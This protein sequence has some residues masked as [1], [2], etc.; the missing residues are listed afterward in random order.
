MNKE[1]A[2]I[3]LAQLESDIEELRKIINKPEQGGIGVVAK[4]NYGDPFA[5]IIP[6][7]SANTPEIASH[8]VKAIQTL[9]RLLSMA[10]PMEENRT[11]WQIVNHQNLSI[12]VDNYCYNFYKLS[13]ISPCF[14]TEE[15]A[16]KAIDT[17]GE[18]AILH[19]MNTFKG[20]YS[21]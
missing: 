11:Q 2:E 15:A 12:V 3:K 4:Y 1:Q 18:E 20:I 7:L 8:H 14:N 10:N 9:Y 21:E 13:E 6:E 16:Q 5:N 19:M 17:I